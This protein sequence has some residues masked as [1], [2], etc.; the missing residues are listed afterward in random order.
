[1]H[2]RLPLVEATLSLQKLINGE[3]KK[4]GKS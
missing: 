3:L 2:V 4:L 1:M